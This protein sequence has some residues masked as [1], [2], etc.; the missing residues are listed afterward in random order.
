MLDE[1]LQHATLPKV[2][3]GVYPS[4]ASGVGIAEL[5]ES[6]DP[7]YFPRIQGYTMFLQR[8]YRMIINQW[9]MFKFNIPIGEMGKKTAYKY[10]DLDKDI[11]LRFENQIVRD[12]DKSFQL[13][14]CVRCVQ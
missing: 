7:V 14:T 5:K 4:P 2:S 9:I 8:L 12:A 1:E 3:Y 10:Q 11:N 13:S 6:E